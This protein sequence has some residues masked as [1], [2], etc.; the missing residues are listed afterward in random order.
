MTDADMIT[1]VVSLMGTPTSFTG[2]ILL[3][4]FAFILTIIGTTGGFI[5]V[6]SIVRRI[7]H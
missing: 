7:I 5:L 4:T 1:T 2:L 6:M 3:Y